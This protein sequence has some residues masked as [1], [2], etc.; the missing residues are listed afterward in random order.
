MEIIW[1]TFKTHYLILTITVAFAL[2]NG[3]TPEARRSGVYK[4]DPVAHFK[5]GMRYWDETRY[6]SAEEEFNFAKSL[7]PKFAPAYS[8][9]SLTIAKKAQNANDETSSADKFKEALKL[10]DKAQSLD[11]TQP[12]VFIAKAFV[13]TMQ[14]ENRPADEWLGDVESEYNKAI[15]LEPQNPES[16]YRRGFCYEKA[17]EFTKAANDFQRVIDL[18]CEFSTKAKKQW[19]LIQIIQH[20][21]PGTSAGKKIALAEQISRA[22]VAALFIAEL[23]IDKLVTTIHIP[24][25]TVSEVPIDKSK[26]YNAESLPE[27]TDIS[28]HWARVFINDIIRF[29]IR[30]LE[31]YPD[32]TFHPNHLVNRGEYAMSIEDALIAITG[33]KSLS[34]KYISSE[35]RFTDVNPAHP[36]YN[37]ICNAVDSGLFDVDST[38]AFGV[39]QPVSGPEA[40]EVIG[41]IRALRKNNSN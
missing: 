27:V 3:C 2:M 23:E 21:V 1:M 9:L 19:E 25:N 11:I 7:N 18:N 16:Y 17:Y 14:N 5:Q 15:K 22:D 10:A 38:G 12:I 13:I 29:D 31:L 30:G 36:A 35:S 26:Q 40:L 33:D 41:K 37:A 24:Y 28:S 34:T 32:H 39:E 6:Q 4:D 8:G 20:A